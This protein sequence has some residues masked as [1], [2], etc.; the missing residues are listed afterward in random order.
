M[1]GSFKTILEEK[2]EEH[3][4]SDKIIKSILD[5]TLDNKVGLAYSNKANFLN[6]QKPLMDFWSNLILGL[7][8]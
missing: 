1:R 6:R 3:N 2:E 7:L 8:N 5:H 4:V